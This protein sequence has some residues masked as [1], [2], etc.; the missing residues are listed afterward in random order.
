MRWLARLGLLVVAVA[1]LVALV[2]WMAPHAGPTAIRSGL[3]AAAEE[4]A[5][6]QLQRIGSHFLGPEVRI[7]RFE[8]TWPATAT[9]HGFQVVQDDVAIIEA[10][11][12]EVR[13]TEAPRA[14][15]PVV[16]E[17]VTARDPVVR[18]IRQPDGSLLGFSGFVKTTSGQVEA[19][20]GSTKPSDVFAI[21]RIGVTG[22]AFRYET[23]DLSAMILD[24]LDF[25]L[26]CAPQAD[27]GW[28]GLTLELA[29]PPVVA[30]AAEGQFS[31]DTA[32]L[33]LRKSSLGVSLSPEQ[34]DVL[35]P[36]L[37]ALMRE[38]AVVG[39]LAMTAAG[40][41]PLASPDAT[42]LDV[43]L[44]LDDASM[45]FGEYVL[46]VDDL[47]VSSSLRDGKVELDPLSATVFGGEA[48]VFGWIDVVTDG[49]PIELAFTGRNMRLEDSLRPAAGQPPKYSG[50]ATVDGTLTCQLRELP[51]SLDGNGT[52]AVDEASLV[53]TALVGAL[54]QSMLLPIGGQDPT[55]SDRGSC[56]FALTDDRVR[57]E[58]IELE[59][60]D[61][62]ARGSGWIGYDGRIQFQFKAGR[63][64]PVRKLFGP[65]GDA[66]GVVADN[67]VTYDVGGAVGAPEVRLRP[68]GIGAGKSP[69]GS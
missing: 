50:R 49:A 53:G 24:G 16:I 47:R 58:D 5:R 10:A 22:G 56:T 64:G 45:A 42:S 11:A 61:R 2:W 55:P 7:E 40:E 3:Q 69:N 51:A 20:G 25:D 66:V 43:T 41:I 34:Y 54:V 9:L 62:A 15:A 28:Y 36:P 65:V 57:A 52:I 32:E 8:Y 37:Q 6:A 68:L 39:T 19:D 48:E 33:V 13:F 38:H 59:G 12:V 23:S 26:R 44:A 31:I 67:L 63:R 21:R 4:W 46:P 17:A 14:G 29:R 27:P 60:G 35:P 18:L 30:G 1:G